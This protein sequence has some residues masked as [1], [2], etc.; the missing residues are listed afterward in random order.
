MLYFL[1]FESSLRVYV[2]FVDK[3]GMHIQHELNAECMTT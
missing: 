1:I 3:I 2:E